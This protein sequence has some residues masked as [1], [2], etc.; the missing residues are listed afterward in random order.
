[1]T[2][3]VTLPPKQDTKPKQAQPRDRQPSKADKAR[4]AAIALEE[5]K[6]GL[7]PLKDPNRLRARDRNGLL[8]LAFQMEQLTDD[9]TVDFEV[10]DPRTMKLLDIL[11]DFDEWAQEHL[12][13]DQQ[14]YETWASTGDVYGKLGDLLGLYGSAVGESTGSSS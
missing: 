5:F 7:P 4:D 8:N 2:D 6:A 9:G 14:A 10:S 12:A 1:M 3:T 11:A 13:L